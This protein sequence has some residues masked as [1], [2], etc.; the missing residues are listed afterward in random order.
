[1]P[2]TNIKGTVTATL[3]LR[4]V[5]ENGLGLSAVCTGS[6]PTT[7]NTFQHGCLMNQTDSGTGS[8]ALYQNTGSSGSP[9]WT[10]LDTSLGGPATSLVDSNGVSAV[11][12]GTTASAVNQLTVTDS[13][14]G[15]VTANAVALTA[16]GTDSA[17]SL[18]MAPK[19]AT[20]I[21][22]IGLATG[23]GDIVVG[24]SSTTQSVKIGNGAGAATV[25]I[26]N[27]STAGNTV[28]VATSAAATSDTINIGTGAT[29]VAGGKTIHIGD[30]T[31][32]GAGTNLI[33]I[34]SIAN[35]A[36][37][38]TIQ[39]GSG[40]TAIALTPQT[41]GVVTMGASAG[42]GDVVVGSSS[43]TQTV[44]LGN[45]AG[46][47]TVNIANVSV[48]GANCNIATAVTGAGITDTVAIS[49]GNAAATG[50]K[51]V[52]ILTGTPGTSGN[53]R[54]TMGGGATSAVTVNAALSSYQAMNFVTGSAAANAPVAT[55]NNAG[56]SAVTVAA[57]LR[58]TLKLAAGLQAGANTFN[59]NSHGT[60]SIKKATNPATDLGTAF[61]TGGIIDL[62]FDGTVWQCIGQ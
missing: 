4:E 53:N 19:G 41:T 50:I 3:F 29:T 12:I 55:L 26:A 24:S 13:A 36:S 43:A 17:V 23:T 57:G 38:T 44:K 20:G 2:G 47:S 11:L 31:P 21:V 46:V 16:T 52:N 33:T 5:D 6:P 10:I 39:G 45:G 60:D 7:T 25:N 35:V 61:A 49:T 14:A 48:A 1:M 22:T 32:T 18:S 34:G 15:A 58:V 8:N 51:A 56:G 9:V 40:A 42:T 37:T 59:L 30:G 28:N 62:I 54:L 27:V